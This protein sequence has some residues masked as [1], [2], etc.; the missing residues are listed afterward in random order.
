MNGDV[1]SARYGDPASAGVAPP[2][3]YGFNAP[4]GALACG[5]YAPPPSS[6]YRFGSISDGPPPVGGPGG[7]GPSSEG[8]SFFDFSMRRHSLTN[9]APTSN[10]RD[11]ST[12]TSGP[13]SLKRKSSGEE[14]VD[15]QFTDSYPNPNY[16]SALTSNGI[17]YPKR[18][19]STVPFDKLDELSLEEQQARRDSGMSVGPPPNWEDERRG[20]YAP[21][22]AADGGQ[23][24]GYPMNYGSTEP[25]DP[26]GVPPHPLPNYGQQQQ[27]Q[28][29]H[30]IQQR[31]SNDQL[32][33]H[34]QQQ[35]HGRGGPPINAGMSPYGGGGGGEGGRRPSQGQAQSLQYAN[36]SN[37]RGIPSQ[38]HSN[39]SLVSVAQS[40]PDGELAR[41]AKSAPMAPQQQSG[42][43][44]GGPNQ[45]PRTSLSASYSNLPSAQAAWARAGPL[46][47]NAH[48]QP[49]PSN[50]SSSSGTLEPGYGPGGKQETPYSRSPELRV[51]HK[52]AER[53]RRKEMAQLFDELRDSLPADR[54]MKSSKWEILSKGACF[55]LSPFSSPRR[56]RDFAQLHGHATSTAQLLDLGL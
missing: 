51:S 24:R 20:S 21:V 9:P 41:S 39:G 1:G 10:N 26:R 16:V 27:H 18:R 40:P 47:S 55:S 32:Y 54:G 46:P 3:G 56:F 14:S 36:Y 49:R 50:S 30:Q 11:P 28:Q 35:Q 37:S 44:P 34:E 52:L 38:H 2:P 43:M 5:P 12:S 23:S 4:L 13:P 7:G 22:G 33:Y 15:E 29:Q 19:G 17:P 48:G 25:H 8:G 6:G 31:M 53:K 45:P 42:G